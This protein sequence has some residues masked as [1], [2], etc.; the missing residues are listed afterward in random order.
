MFTWVGV[1][2]IAWQVLTIVLAFRYADALSALL[3]GLGIDAPAITRSFLASYRWWIVAPVLAALL[4]A[5]VARR[6]RPPLVYGSIVLV[7]SVVVALAL[8]AWMNEA[9]FGVLFTIMAKVR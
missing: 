1:L 9:W 4:V 2:A 3:S 6:S 5:D 8:H 7:T